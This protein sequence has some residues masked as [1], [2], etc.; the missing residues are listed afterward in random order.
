MSRDSK[1]WIWVVLSE[2][3]AEVRMAETW[4]TVSAAIWL[5]LKARQS[6]VARAASCPV[7][8]AAICA[9]VK[10]SMME[11]ISLSF[12]ARGFWGRPPTWPCLFRVLSIGYRWHSDTT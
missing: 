8:S 12:C 3:S 5:V 11:A 10:P 4:S 1:A 2:L 7:V 6:E 9:V